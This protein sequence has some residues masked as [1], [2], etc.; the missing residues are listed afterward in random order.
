[1]PTC[2]LRKS[3]SCEADRA[4]HRAARR[5]LDA[6]EHELGIRADVDFAAGHQ[7]LLDDW[8]HGAAGY[9]ACSARRGSRRL[10]ATPRRVHRAGTAA[11]RSRP[12]RAAAAVRTGPRPDGPML[13][14]VVRRRSSAAARR[15]RACRSASRAGPC[16]ASPRRAARSRCA[17]AS[18]RGCPPPSSRPSARTGPAAATAGAAARPPPAERSPSTCTRPCTARNAS[19]RCRSR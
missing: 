10:A 2:G 11:H 5:L 8:N 18:S 9:C 16:S 4:Q 13:Q 6:V 14:Q 1:M 15:D 12:A 19:T 7:R 3:R 17:R